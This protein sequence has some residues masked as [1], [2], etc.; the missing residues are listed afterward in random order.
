MEAGD[1]LMPQEQYL[2][3]DPSAGQAI[4]GGY[5]SRDSHAGE[6]AAVKPSATAT[7][8]P[9]ALVAALQSLRE[10]GGEATQGIN[11]RN[12][13][14]GLQRAFWHPVQTAIDLQRAQDEVRQQAAEA[15][16][17]GDTLT[18]VRKGIEWLI[19]LMGP[20]L[21][22]ASDALQRG[23]YAKGLG[24]TADAAGMVVAP[25]VAGGI[26]QSVRVPG[27]T[28]KAASLETSAASRI[29]DV[30]APKVGA[31]KVRFGN[32]A[33]DVAPAIARDLAK[34]GAPWTREALQAQVADKLADARSGLDAASDAR[35][36][37]QA[38]ETKPI[39]DAL[40]EKRRKLTAESVEGSRVIPASQGEA[41]RGA[42]V[43]SG[44][45][46]EFSAGPDISPNDLSRHEIGYR[47]MAGRFADEPARTGRPI[48]RDVVPSPNAARVAAIDQ[49]ISEV[50]ALGPVARYEALRRIRAAWDGPAKVK[51][52]PSVTADFLKNQGHA[53][54]AADVTGVLREQLARFDPETASANATYSLYQSA[55]D[56]M[57]ATAEIERTRP[58]AGRQ[59]M[60]R[61]TGTI[62]GGQAAGVP[63]MAAGYVLGPVMDSA[64]SAG[65]T[66]QLK[67]AA[68]MQRLADAIKSGNL[69]LADTTISQLKTAATAP[70]LSVGREAGAML[71]GAPAAASDE[72]PDGSQRK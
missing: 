39:L 17:Q 27:A 30:M 11:P 23:Q 40:L 29:A 7:D 37:G 59:I 4:A 52:N 45:D 67:T 54:G 61:L 20:R 66:T 1:A 28:A 68:L 46:T 22:Q 35:L 31:N 19:P 47:T 41:V 32:T 3:T 56:V 36:N 34:D 13:N 24:A 48:G 18:G 53:N 69:Q 55:D 26:L 8:A 57:R 25:D 51:Y 58:R 64:L 10:F 2:S 38:F 70:R 72:T 49:A 71:R 12:I 43:T 60:A 50:K 33:R 65:A 15:F 9:S 63:G 62:A 16:R 14:Q 44:P 42:R 6:N 5:L 21:N